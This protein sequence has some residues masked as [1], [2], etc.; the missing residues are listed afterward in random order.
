MVLSRMDP[1]GMTPNQD[2]DEANQDEEKPTWK[3]AGVGPD[4]TAHLSWF[5][6]L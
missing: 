1:C 2:A 6:A 5:A 4:S 3:R